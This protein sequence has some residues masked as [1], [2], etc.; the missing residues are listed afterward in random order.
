MAKATTTIRQ[1]IQHEPQHAA[2]FAA[3]QALFNQVA[4]FYFEV[5]AAHEKILDLSGQEALTVLERLTHATTR[6]P[7][8]VMPLTAI[9]EDA[10][11]M[12]RRAA[13]HAALGSARSFFTHLHKWRARKEK[14]LA[15]GK[16]F[17]ER[18]PVPPRTWKKSVPF[19]AGLWKERTEKSILLKVWT[20]ESWSWLKLTILG[21]DLPETRQL[22]Y[23]PGTDLASPSLVRRGD[24][25]WLHTPI[26][27]TFTTPKKVVTQVTTHPETRLCAVD[28]NLDGP[29]AVCTIQTVEGTT[30]ATRFLKGG[31]AV[32]GLRKRLLG[33]IAR[34][35]RKTGIIAADEQD[36]G[37]LWNKI[38]QVD[39]QLAHRV[40]ARIVEF[41]R[42]HGATLLVF[43]HLGNL[44]PTKGRY[45]RRGN[46]KRAFWMK[47]RIFRY[48]QYKAWHEEI[49]TSRV[50]P[51][52]TSRECARCGGLVIRYEEGQ[53]E[54]G[55]TTG[56]PLVRCPVC[57][58]RGH[59]D[60]NASL[61]IG[62]RLLTRCQNPRK[63]KPHTPR[64]RTG[65]PAKA[66]GVALSQDAQSQKGPSILAAR[67]GDHNGHGTAHEGTTGMADAPSGIPRPLRPFTE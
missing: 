3:T 35:R 6:N 61:K 65:R 50:N 36:N 42:E 15:K 63:E 21:R 46:T 41:A 5:I 38:R 58:M 28:L 9:V 18:P 40:S 13:I 62:Q 59:S 51:R 37:A 45:S 29:L 12:F 26:E 32:S 43:E 11:A 47:A 44:K 22:N 54:E 24:R 2:W 52:N 16:P 19:Y 57:K 34:N 20:G 33:R 23:C 56:A 49:I 39:E 17:R 31:R 14:A 7:H 8:P 4:A 48:A 27:Q 55:Y 67:H 53:P 10:P 1:T 60:R 30:I 64:S 66:G 25:W